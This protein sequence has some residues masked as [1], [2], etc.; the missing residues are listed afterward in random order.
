MPRYDRKCPECGWEAIDL[1]ER[2]DAKLL[3]PE[4]GEPTERAYLTTAASVIG[5][6][7]DAVLTN[8]SKQPWR[9]R[10][11]Q[12]HRDWLKANGYRIKDDHVGEQ[13]SDKNKFTSRSVTMDPQTLAN[14][15]ALVTRAALEPARGSASETIGLTSNEGVIRY[16]HDRARIERG[17]FL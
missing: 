1:W 3:C 11:K 12:L 7:M 15:T 5:D 16:L 14:A 4:C 10:S 17:E 9:C 6:E 2:M 8:G 13:G